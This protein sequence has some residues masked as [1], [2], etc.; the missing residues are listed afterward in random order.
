MGAAAEDQV[1][2]TLRQITRAIDISS[3]KLLK[4][5]GLSGPQLAVI[6]IIAEHEPV[7]IK[8]IA[9]EVSLSSPTVLGILERL[10]QRDL[11]SKLRS[12]IDKRQ[13]YVQIT[14]KG[15]EVLAKTRDP[16]REKFSRQ[17]QNLEAWEKSL[18]LSSLQR[19]SAMLS[20]EDLDVDSFLYVEEI[21]EP[22]T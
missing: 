19:I 18:I 12:D 8:R 21:E 4:D 22:K 6:R 16:L 5:S 14:Q 2:L 11:V 15:H 13:S 3:K 20:A 7:S 9:T 17:F 1:I 10:I